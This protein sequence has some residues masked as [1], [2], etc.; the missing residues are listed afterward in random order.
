MTRH[1]AP[2]IGKPDARPLEFIAPVQ[3]LKHT[4]QSTD[5][6]RVEANPVVTNAQ[7]DLMALLPRCDLNQCRLA[8][9]RVLQRVREQVVEHLAQQPHVSDHGW[10]R[11]DSPLHAALTLVRSQ[12]G[13]HR[14]HQALQIDGAAPQLGPRGT[15]EFQ[16]IVDQ[17][18]HAL[19]RFADHL[20]V[21][22]G[23][24]SRA[25]ATL[26]LEQ[27]GK[28]QDVP[29]WGAEVVRHRVREGFQFAVGLAQL[30]RALGHPLL[31]RIVEVLQRR[32]GQVQPGQQVAVA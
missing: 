24:G 4:E 9:A 29:Q 11:P 25:L 31:Q 23:L 3:T 28:P 30:R 1:D 26:A 13:P 19:R 17:P 14:L 20:Q 16:Q 32:A 10:Q 2:D 12:I 18:A 7:P 21:T 6:F 27:V 5:I 22:G 15:R 8:G